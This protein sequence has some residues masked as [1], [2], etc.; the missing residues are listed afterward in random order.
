MRFDSQKAFPYPVLRPDIDDYES[1]EFQTTVDIVSSGDNKKIVLKAHIALSIDEIKKEIASGNACVSLI[2]SCRETYF[3]DA[4]TSKKLD[5]EK[6]F[7]S[8]LFKGEVVVSPFIVATKPIKKFRCRDI[9]SEFGVKEF[10][11][12]V[13]EVL[14][15]DEPRMVFIDRELFKPIS[16][17]L[18]LVKQD[19]LVGFDWRLR[20]EENK[21][22]LQLSPEAKDEIDRARNS[23]RNK[24]VLIN[25]LY[26]AAI[27]EA[28]HKLREDEETFADFRWAKILMQQCHNNSIDYRTHDA[29]E[30][31]QRLLK[32][33]LS[34]L[35]QYVFADGG[36]DQ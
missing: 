2:I 26:F 7:T 10:S 27:V 21:I 24:A 30:T 36:D 15:A 3:R 1:G 22:Q 12:E 4:I 32:S 16:S 25:S 14:A 29:C 11:F 31:A 28:I 33:P 18:Q 13:G 20:F 8:G 9:N 6:A 34:L 35:K 23:R 19:S 5:I 17:I